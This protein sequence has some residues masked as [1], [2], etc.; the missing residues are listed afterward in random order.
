MIKISFHNFK[1]VWA[2]RHHWL[3]SESRLIGW[4]SVSGCDVFFR[5]KACAN[6]WFTILQRRWLDGVWRILTQFRQ[7]TQNLINVVCCCKMEFWW[8]WCYEMQFDLVSTCHQ[9]FSGILSLFII[10]IRIA[11]APMFFMCCV[12]SYWLC[13]IIIPLP[14]F[15]LRTTFTNFYTMSTDLIFSR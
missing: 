11:C 2:G 8:S 10:F 13:P 1:S 15:Y 14:Y 7:Q 5:L 3:H 4:L 9:R 12:Y 6:V